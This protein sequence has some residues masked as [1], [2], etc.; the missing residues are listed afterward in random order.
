M[1]FMFSKN[2]CVQQGAFV[3]IDHDVKFQD[4]R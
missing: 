4:G 1:N 2:E 3:S